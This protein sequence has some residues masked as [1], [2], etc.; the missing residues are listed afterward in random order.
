MTLEEFFREVLSPGL[1]RCQVATGI[2]ASLEAARILLAIRMQ[3]GDPP[4]RYQ[5]LNSGR[6]GPARGWWQFERLGG[7]RGVMT[8]SATSERAR[9]LCDACHVRFIDSAVWRALEGH[10]ALAV[11]FARLLLWSDPRPL[12]T[13]EADGWAYYLRNWRPG[14]PRPADWPRNWA[15]AV[16]VVG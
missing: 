4:S 9:R 10:D 13:N 2:P 8:H 6:P 5:I 12:P 15:A 14:K 3:E 7:V 11:G 1:A 16:A